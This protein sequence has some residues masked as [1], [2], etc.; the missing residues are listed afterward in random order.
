MNMREAGAGRPQKLHF[1]QWLRVALISLVVSHH[2]AQPYG[3][4]GGAWPIADPVSS[5]VLLPFFVLNAAFF[6]GFFFLI[7]GYFT[8]APFERKGAGA[9]VASRLVR[10]GVP[11]VVLGVFVNG[12]LIWAGS[13]SGA[14]F[15]RFLVTE[16]LGGLRYELGPLWFIAHLLVYGLG[17]AA[18]RAVVPAGPWRPAPP[19]HGAI[20]AYIVALGVVTVAVRA[21]WP[22]DVW[23]RILWLI[24]AEAAHLPQYLSLFVI[25][26]IAA[27]GRWFT[28]ISS[29]VA[30]TWFGV[31]AAVFVAL[32]AL[33]GLEAPLPGFVDLRMIWGFFEGFVT[34]GMILGLLAL[35][36]ARLAEPGPVLG[37]L[38]GSVY[39][40]YLV[41]FYVV[42]VLQGAL[43]GVALPALA[44]FALV[45]VAG[46]VV[47]FALVDMLRRLRWVR[48]VI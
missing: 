42:L 34:V 2:A 16:Y 28:E 32:S 12:A 6:M 22:I 46:T 40:V 18:W 13:E 10:L 21:V 43:V 31:G 4:T 37:R 44:K 19:G 9:F 8:E 30:Y 1:V 27:R 38:E 15:W 26:I 39:G 20:L 7:A 48:A 25:G 47:S 11:L 33:Y 23:V 14:G 3:P 41:H 29:A 35:F 24:P 45:S 17:F 36:R 5:P